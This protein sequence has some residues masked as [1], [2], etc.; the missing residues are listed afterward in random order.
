MHY[1]WGHSYYNLTPVELGEGGGGGGGGL[2]FSLKSVRRGGGGG[3]CTYVIKLILHF[4]TSV[5]GKRIY[6]TLKQLLIYMKKSIVCVSIIILNQHV[7]KSTK[8]YDCNVDWQDVNVISVSL[9]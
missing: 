1:F 3:S 8:S 7:R 6:F 4:Y 5:L 2:D 9:L